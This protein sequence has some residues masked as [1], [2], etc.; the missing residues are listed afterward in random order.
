[1]GHPGVRLD[2]RRG[3]HVVLYCADDEA[4]PGVCERGRDERN[5]GTEGRQEG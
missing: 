4:R 2:E 1:M 3:A 5:Q